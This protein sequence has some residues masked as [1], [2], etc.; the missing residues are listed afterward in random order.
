MS[1]SI[2]FCLHFFR[3]KTN[4][5]VLVTNLLSENK[6]IT[7]CTDRYVESEK[8]MDLCLLNRTLEYFQKVLFLHPPLNHESR[9]MFLH[10][11]QTNYLSRSKLSDPSTS[12]W[13]FLIFLLDND[14]KPTSSKKVYVAEVLTLFVDVIQKDIEFFWKHHNRKDRENIPLVKWLFDVTSTSYNEKNVE[15]I[16]DR[17]MLYVKVNVYNH[18]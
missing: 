10:T 16:L 2:D 12:L 6:D 8:I 13:Q 5:K 9:K 14:V 18:T 11:F 1:S 3:E 7:S 4:N 17:F 15:K